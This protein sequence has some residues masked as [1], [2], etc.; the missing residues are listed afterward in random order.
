MKRVCLSEATS[1]DPMDQAAVGHGCLF[2]SSIS[3]FLG[4]VGCIFRCLSSELSV[5]G[6]SDIEIPGL[7]IFVGPRK[8][9]E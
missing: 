5:A 9:R 1:V 6:G 7:F 8:E 2:G 4:S 3:C